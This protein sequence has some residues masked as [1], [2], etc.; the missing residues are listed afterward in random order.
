LLTGTNVTRLL[1]VLNVVAVLTVGL[2]SGTPETILPIEIPEPNVIDISFYFLFLL[3]GDATQ[4]LGNCLVFP[5]QTIRTPPA[6]PALPLNEPDP[7]PPPMAPP[8]PPPN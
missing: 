4:V 8:P 1:D 3:Y 7:P 6:E 2:G 5:G